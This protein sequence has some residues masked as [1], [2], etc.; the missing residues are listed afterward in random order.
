MATRSLCL[1]R[2]KAFTGV[3]A[4]FFGASDLRRRRFTKRSRRVSSPADMPAL[5]IRGA[6]M[7][8]FARRSEMRK[9]S[10]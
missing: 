8:F 7:M 1:V 5:V 2:L 4:E 6:S 3:G 9:L 10:S